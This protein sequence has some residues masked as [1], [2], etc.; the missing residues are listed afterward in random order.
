[1]ATPLHLEFERD[2]VGLQKQID[3]L[4]RAAEEK[5]IDVSDEVRILGRKLEVLRE[6]IFQNLTP[7]EQVQVARHPKRP[8]TLD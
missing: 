7:L 8:Y 4:L 5:G 1:M 3:G 6:E 2:I